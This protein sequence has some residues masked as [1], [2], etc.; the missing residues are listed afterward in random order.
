MNPCPKTGIPADYNAKLKNQELF[1]KL[2]ILLHLEDCMRS[3]PFESY[4]GRPVADSIIIMCSSQAS[5]LL[6]GYCIQQV[7]L[8]LQ[9]DTNRP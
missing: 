3:P 9:I 5:L 1:D 4:Y 6:P 2:Q 7:S 8:A